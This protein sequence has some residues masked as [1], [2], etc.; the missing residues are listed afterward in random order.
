MSNFALQIWKKYI[1]ETL[2]LDIVYRNGGTAN[3]VLYSSL[4]FD[5][6]IIID[7]A[8][9]FNITKI[10]GINYENLPR[11]ILRG[12]VVNKSMLS[13]ATCEIAEYEDCYF[14]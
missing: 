4:P 11:L 13:N 6:D 8:T 2:H 3:S 14:V 10:S 1:A 9:I 12:C 7:N 5:R